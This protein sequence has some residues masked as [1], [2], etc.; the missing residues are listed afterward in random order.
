MKM[1][2]NNIATKAHFDIPKASGEEG[3]DGVKRGWMGSKEREEMEG[4]RWRGEGE[5]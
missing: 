5:E 4:E 3:R 1:Q 2:G